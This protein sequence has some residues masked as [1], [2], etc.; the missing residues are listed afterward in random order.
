M[1]YGGA[2][3]TSQ[4]KTFV[5]GNR[6]YYVEA[7]LQDDYGS[8]TYEGLL[9]L[10][11]RSMGQV[12]IKREQS[13]K[14]DLFIENEL[15]ILDILHGK[16]VPQWKHLPTVL[17]RFSSAGR[18]GMVL[19]R[20]GGHSLTEVRSHRLHRDGVDERHM[21]W[22]LDRALSCLG[23]VHQCGVVHGNLTPEN[24]RIDAASHNVVIGGW[25]AAAHNPAI[26]AEQIRV[27]S[28]EFGAPEV[29]EQGEIGPWSDIY[30]LGKIMIWLLGGN[31]LTNQMPKGIKAPIQSFLLEMVN[32]DRFQR[33]SDAWALH[34]EETRIKDALWRRQFLHFDIS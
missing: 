33:P 9:E 10:E 26:T 13:P 29:K 34:A 20:L 19:Q 12:T 31:H 2:L 25:G 8:S 1:G 18:A 5:V 7:R 16:S 6:R 30:S 28:D 22:M 14:G 17:D 3:P 27:F 21:V 24:M 11:G 4:S 23:Y 15:R 32:E